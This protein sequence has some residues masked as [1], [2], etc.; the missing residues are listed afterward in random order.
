MGV[1]AAAAR[2]FANYGA[3]KRQAA[4]LTE[5]LWSWLIWTT[6]TMV[7]GFVLL[8][9]VW[10]PD[11]LF[12]GQALGRAFGWMLHGP[13]GVVPGSGGLADVA[14]LML[15]TSTLGGWLGWMHRHVLQS[16]AI[17]TTGLVRTAILAAAL[18]PPLVY[19]MGLVTG[20][21]GHPVSWVL[22][23]PMIAT[24]MAVG[25]WLVGRRD[26]AN[27][28][29]LIPAA[30]VAWVLPTRSVVGVT[31]IALGP[32]V[33][34]VIATLLD[35]PERK[36]PRW[37]PPWAIMPAVWLGP[38]VALAF[39]VLGPR[40]LSANVQQV[41]AETAA[42]GAG[43]A[44]FQAAGDSIIVD[45]YRYN[46]QGSSLE[47][48]DS[49]T[50]GPAR[51]VELR[52]TRTTPNQQLRKIAAVGNAAYILASDGGVFLWGLDITDRARPASP[53]RL[54]IDSPID[55]APLGRFLVMIRHQPYP[56]HTVTVFDTS[57]PKRPVQ[58]GFFELGDEP[59]DLAV[60]GNTIQISQEGQAAYFVFTPT[61]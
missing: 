30:A 25:Y 16:L 32:L 23:G 2:V 13:A 10:V 51:Y 26:V 41:N 52:D 57:D 56:Y 20:G 37:A 46:V 44:S 3:K 50:G 14:A 58:A 45:G 48:T 17:P 35:Q 5:M 36:L 18:G 60:A 38:I 6:A 27:A 40:A 9:L 33:G 59:R 12:A 43:Q 21:L 42:A 24:V 53:E 49:T 15:A 55:I 8:L 28:C 47:I 39:G 61:R 19:L 34:V 1:D 7:S 54:R 4:R 22:I 11:L 29:W 31:M